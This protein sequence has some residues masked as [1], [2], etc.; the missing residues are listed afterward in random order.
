MDT[1]GEGFG[2][3]LWLARVDRGVSRR[4][5]AMAV[6]KSPPTVARWE[7][8]VQVPK[9][10]TEAEQ[11]AIARILDVPVAWVQ[12]GDEATP[13]ASRPRFGPRVLSTLLQD[14]WRHMDAQEQDMLSAMVRAAIDQAR[15]KRGLSPL[16]K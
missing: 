8:S 7:K 5:L 9:A 4:A 1:Y 13:P 15:H 10:C 12:G 16:P 2:F 6:R 14:N 11:E 3:R